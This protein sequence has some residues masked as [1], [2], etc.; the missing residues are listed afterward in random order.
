MKCH[1]WY[2]LLNVSCDFDIGLSNVM[3]VPYVTCPV[4]D[5][6]IK[7]FMK[8]DKIARIASASKAFMLKR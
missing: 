1:L 7:K 5:I 2:Y 8:I 3:F 4:R 6:E